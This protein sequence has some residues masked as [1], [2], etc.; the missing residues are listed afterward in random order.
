M[1]IM[2]AGNDP[3]YEIM[4]NPSSY[5]PGPM[6]V[7]RKP[8][9][10]TPEQ[11]QEE[12]RH[13]RQLGWMVGLSALAILFLV[14]A[15]YVPVKS[16]FYRMIAPR[17]VME[18]RLGHDFAALAYDHIGAGG[19]P[20]EVFE[21]HL[22]ALQTAGFVPI[23]LGDV[24]G[25]LRRGQLLPLN[26]VLITLDHASA[27]TWEDVSRALRQR[28]WY[29][30]VFLTTGATPPHEPAPPSWSALRMG[31]GERRWEMGTQGHH[32]YTLIPT[33]PDQGTSPFMLGLRWLD[34]YAR[35]ETVFD[36]QDRLMEDQLL[37]RDTI[38][39]RLGSMATV[40][41]YPDGNL[42]QRTLAHPALNNI[43]MAVTAR[44]FDLAFIAGQLA[45]NNAWSDPMR[46]NRLEVDASWSGAALVNHLDSLHA[47]M[48]PQVPF[49]RDAPA[50]G[51]WVVSGGDAHLD[52]GEM[53]LTAAPGEPSPLLW[54]AGSDE[55]TDQI[56]SGQYRLPAGRLRFYFRTRWDGPNGYAVEL[57]AEGHLRLLEMSSAGETVLAEHPITPTHTESHSIKVFLR[58]RQVQVFWDEGAVWTYPVRLPADTGIGYSGIGLLASH[59]DETARVLLSKLRVERVPDRLVYGEHP[60][61]MDARAFLALRSEGYRYRMF[62][63]AWDS[64]SALAETGPVD[65]M[66]ARMLEAKLIPHVDISSDRDPFMNRPAVDWAKPFVDQDCDGVLVRFTG[67]APLSMGDLVA[68]LLEAQESLKRAGKEL[69]VRLPANMEQV[70]VIQSLIGYVP[71]LQIVTAQLS[72]EEAKKVEAPL[73]VEEALDS[74]SGDSEWAA[75]QEIKTDALQDEARKRRTRVDR[76]KNEGLEAL[77]QGNYEKAIVHFSDWHNEVPTLPEPLN[78][79]GEAL[80]Q[81]DFRDEAVEFFEQSLDLDPAQ[82]E[83]AVKL[84]RLLD[85]VKRGD[86]SRRLLNRYALLFPDEPSILLAQSE[87]LFYRNRL[88][89]ARPRMARLL[90]KV[91]DNLDAAILFLR[92]AHRDQDRWL[93]LQTVLRQGRLP[94]NHLRVAEAIRDYDLLT[95]PDM[96]SLMDLLETIALETKNVRV[97]QIVEELRPKNEAVREDLTEGSWS[98]WWQPDGV[99]SVHTNEGAQLRAMA[100]RTDY[101][102]RLSGSQAWRDAYVK[103]TIRPEFGSFWLYARRSASQHVRFGFNE[104]MD[105]LHLQVWELRNNELFLTVSESAEWKPTGHPLKLRLDLRGKAAMGYVNDEPAFPKPLILP[106][107]LGLGRVAV[108]GDALEAGRAE[109]LLQTLEAGPIPV[110]LAMFDPAVPMTVTQRLER[111]QAMRTHITNLAPVWFTQDESGAWQ[112]TLREE[113]DLYRLFAGYYGLRLTPVAVLHDLKS[114]SLRDL[115]LLIQVHELDGL[116][117]QCE[118]LPNAETMEALRRSPEAADMDLI[119]L[120]ESA[121]LQEAPFFALGASQNLSRKVHEAGQLRR[122]T[123]GQAAVLDDIAPYAPAIIEVDVGDLR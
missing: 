70:A 62:S 8:K 95:T 104:D 35:M 56:L 97:L 38:Q 54:I 40:F 41:A 117:L 3:R 9:P 69:L 94:A 119:I 71:G 27:E 58:G 55:W 109:V 5:P 37:A 21:D 34:T 72:E 112:S 32:G 100:G 98:R 6:R 43:R 99:V 75:Y 17:V 22:D 122:I 123:A 92:M 10:E 84:A 77:H 96:L 83:L 63:P 18:P 53:A 105:R 29:G 31:V 7:Y 107:S 26:A 50:Y 101:A 82:L 87:W 106:A 93:A 73:I 19:V 16:L 2:Q 52:R 116:I 67:A 91:P 47:A 81:M 42:G 1:I 20:L 65:R 59:E 80:L 89:E 68:W 61:T 13:R 48:A 121:G 23:R 4:T 60:D 11:Q 110:R 49:G 113:D 39:A 24:R 118:T 108:G 45:Y 66:A 79:I 57:D 44:N 120:Q 90:S 103:T 78:L 28:G 15:W 46:L 102:L 111:L 64:L 85:A 86:E 115:H 30:V 14:V 88:A 33:D 36:F 74:R 76:M 25:L 51:A 12:I 114:L